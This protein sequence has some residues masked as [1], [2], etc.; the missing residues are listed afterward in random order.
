MTVNRQLR[1]NSHLDSIRGFCL[2]YSEHLTKYCALLKNPFLLPLRCPLSPSGSIEET[3]HSL[4]LKMDTTTE[5]S[6]TIYPTA[7][8]FGPCRALVHLPSCGVTSHDLPAEDVHHTRAAGSGRFGQGCPQPT[9]PSHHCFLQF[10]GGH[11]Q[12]TD[13]F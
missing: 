11:R 13:T 8:S 7:G 2:F 3:F 9:C 6:S 1:R 12:L 10:P 4:A 5:E